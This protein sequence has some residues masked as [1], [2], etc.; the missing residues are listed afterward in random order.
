LAKPKLGI[1]G[2]KR[3]EFL[4]KDSKELSSNDEVGFLSEP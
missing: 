3:V 2:V 1:P 4:N